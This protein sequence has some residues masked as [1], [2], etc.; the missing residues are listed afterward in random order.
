MKTLIKPA[1][2]ICIAFLSAC[3][4]FIKSP[5]PLFSWPLKN[6]RLSQTYA[7]LWNAAHQGIDLAAPKGTPVFSS[8]TGKVVYAGKRLSGY[9]K[10]V[11]IEYSSRWSTLYAHLETIHVKT[12]WII[13]QGHQLGTVGQTGNAKGAHLHFE[14]LYKKQP[15]NPLLYLP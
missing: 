4:L 9:G 10:T 12:G 2:L 1:L 3:S 11:I 7:P 6:Y 14:M 15:V 13:A 5:P 8:H